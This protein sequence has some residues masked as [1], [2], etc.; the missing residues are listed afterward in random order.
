M[1]RSFTYCLPT[2]LLATTNPVTWFHCNRVGGIAVKVRTGVINN[3]MRLMNTG[4]KYHWKTGCLLVASLTAVQLCQA[5]LPTDGL[6]VQLTGSS[7]ITLSGGNS[8]DTWTDLEPTGGTPVLNAG[9]TAPT[10][11]S[12]SF[13]SGSF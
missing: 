8:V 10:Q 6:T 12:E 3:G 11:A 4:F 2:T 5:A 13:G 1:K 9:A 7:G